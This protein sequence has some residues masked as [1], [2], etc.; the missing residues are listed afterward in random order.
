[1]TEQ[2]TNENEERNKEEKGG[3]TGK[4]R[5]WDRAQEEKDKE[6][7]EKGEKLTNCWNTVVMGFF[8]TTYIFQLLAPLCF[9]AFLKDN[10]WL[11]ISEQ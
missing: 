3:G 8:S 4:K 6:M 9:C 7:E 10:D 5:K 1:M 11:Y 2:K